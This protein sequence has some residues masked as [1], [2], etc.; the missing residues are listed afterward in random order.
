MG[1]SN[2][3]PPDFW[4]LQNAS[5]LVTQLEWHQHSSVCLA[6]TAITCDCLRRPAG[7]GIAV[8]FE[9][10]AARRAP[11]PNSSAQKSQW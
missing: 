9:M 6:W 8:Y 10:R 3:P 1:D 11:V 5:G 4:H 7:T 2:F